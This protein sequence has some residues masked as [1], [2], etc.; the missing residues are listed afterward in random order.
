M[1]KNKERIDMPRQEIEK[2]IRNFEEVALGYTEQMALLEAERCLNCKDPLCVKGCPVNVKIPEFIRLINEKKYLDALKKIKET[3]SLPAVCGRVCP[4]EEQCEAACVLSKAK[5]PIAIGR[6][7]RYVADWVSLMGIEEEIPQI[8]K[9]NIKVAVIGSGPGGL[10]CAA[11]LAL[12]GYEVTIFEALHKAG[13]VLVYGIPEFRLPKRIVEREVEYL[14]KLGVEIK[15]N[16][17]VG[18][19]ITLKDL[20]EEGYKAV[21]LGLGAGLPKFMNLKGENLLN[22]YSANEYLTRTNLMKA[23]RFPEYDTPIKKG[24]RVAV[25]GGGNVAMDAVRSALRYG[26]SE[27]MIVYRRSKQ[28]LPAREEEVENAEAEGVKFNFLVN[29]LEFIGDENGFVK[30][31]KLQK[32]ELGEPDESGRRRPVPVEGSEFYLDVD[33]VVI[34]IGQTANPVLLD[35]TPEV[36]RNKWGYIE[37]CDEYGRTSMKGVFAGGDIVT[38]EATVIQAMGSGKKSALGIDEYIKTG[39]WV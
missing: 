37:V 16:V 33:V 27:A 11:D 4:Q 23:Y 7:E 10:T 21:Y 19:S 12:M 36:K 28:E 2:R 35:V 6:L 15:T 26:A 31:I 5:K 30:K 38:G 1:A 22:I 20:F 18:K 14:E 29:P 25:I 13:G 34:A 3:N 32:M 39:K 8:N 24:K 17:V 9:N